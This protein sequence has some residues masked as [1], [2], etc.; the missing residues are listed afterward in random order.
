M[1]RAAVARDTMM[2]FTAKCWRR[3][4][5][6]AMGKVVLFRSWA[7]D[8]QGGVSVFFGTQHTRAPCSAVHVGSTAPAR[9]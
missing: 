5:D 8:G 6:A 4:S 2:R 3:V 1:H 9:A 7:L